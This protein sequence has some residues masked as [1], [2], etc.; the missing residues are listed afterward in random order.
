MGHRHR[1]QR[2]S[3]RARSAHA[4]RSGAR[5][6]GQEP[7]SF[8]SRAEGREAWKRTRRKQHRRRSCDPAGFWEHPELVYITPRQG[9]RQEAWTASLNK[10]LAG[11]TYVRD[12]RPGWSSGSSPHGPSAQEGPRGLAPAL[13]TGATDL[14][15]RQCVWGGSG[16][17]LARVGMGRNE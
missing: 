4:P 17:A 5:P 15:S 3:I 8:P 2:G 13:G 6:P 16:R 14:S 9:S 11:C 7:C 12:P 10:A 1:S